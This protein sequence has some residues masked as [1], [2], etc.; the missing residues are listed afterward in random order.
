[1][2]S[3]GVSPVLTVALGSTSSTSA[4]S[5]E[6]G[7]CDVPF[8]TTKLPRAQRHV[9]VVHPDRQRTRQHKE[10]LV[11][12]G[13]AVAGE[14]TV[15]ADDAYVVVVEEGDGAGLPRSLDPSE[16]GGEV[17]WCGHNR[18]GRWRMACGTGARPCFS[19][20]AWR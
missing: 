10:D 8:G 19:A 17:D 9:A 13:M 4:P 18:R 5:G 6:Y 11:G 7:W 12:L 16:D 3:L 15:G 20:P 14:L 2:S 1:V